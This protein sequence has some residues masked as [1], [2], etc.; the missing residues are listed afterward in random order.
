MLIIQQ[1][2]YI[3]LVLDGLDV[4]AKGGA[5]D[6]GVLTIDLQHNRCLT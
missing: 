3:L 1:K 5:D 6:T 4:E 2:E